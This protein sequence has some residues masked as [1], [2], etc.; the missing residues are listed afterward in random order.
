MLDCY[1]FCYP[2]YGYYCIYLSASSRPKPTADLSII[3]G[4]PA[5]EVRAVVFVAMAAAATISRFLVESGH[6]GYRHF[7]CYCS[8]RPFSS[9]VPA[10]VAV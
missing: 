6:D 4:Q 3:I 2:F 1:Q 9:S 10:A 7:I 5:E 8:I